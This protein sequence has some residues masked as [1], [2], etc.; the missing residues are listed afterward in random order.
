[1]ASWH[2]SGR[3]RG[4]AGRSWAQS[5][6]A[7][8]PPPPLPSPPPLALLYAPPLPYLSASFRGAPAA[9]LNPRPAPLLGV[10]A[11]VR[12][13]VPV[14]AQISRGALTRSLRT[15]RVM[16]GAPMRTRRPPVAAPVRA[17]AR[18]EAPERVHTMTP[19]R[20]SPAISAA[21]A[22]AP[23]PASSSRSRSRASAAL[24]SGLLLPSCAGPVMSAVMSAVRCRSRPTDVAVRKMP[25][26]CCRTGRCVS[27]IAAAPPGPQAGPSGKQVSSFNR[28]FG[29]RAPP[30][31]PPR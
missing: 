17:G 4:G 3:S 23:L 28:G 30:A 31:S 19:V 14:L 8:P 15:K 1:M 24:T 12:T 9:A 7:P 26:I 13:L 11:S 2:G 18:K 22:A 16:C 29:R 5:S 21:A 20:S 10:F 6:A 27:S 25:K